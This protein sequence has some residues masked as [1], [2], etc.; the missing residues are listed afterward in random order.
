MITASG[1]G[2]GLDVNSLVRQLVQSERASFDQAINRQRSRVEP[3]LSAL[4]EFKAAASRV[5]EAANPLR[6]AANYDRKQAV[7][8]NT[9]ALRATASSVAVPATYQVQV[10]NIATTQ[11]IASTS[12]SSVD[13]VV[14]KGNLV[15]RFGTTDYSGGSYNGFTVNPDRNPFTITIDDDN[16]SLI[17]VMQA[18]NESNQGVNASIVNDGAGFRLLITTQQ[19]GASNSIEIS[20]TG[21]TDGNNND[22]N[23]LSR[24]AFNATASNMQQTQAANDLSFT[25]N[26]LTIQNQNNT[27]ATAI[28]GVTLNF[29]E[30][31]SSPFTL[32]VRRDTD[33]ILNAA[34]NFV[35]AYNDFRA[36]VTEISGYDQ[37]TKTAGPLIS[38]FT[39]RSVVRDIEGIL[40]GNLSNLPA[41][42][43]NLAE[44]GFTTNKGGILELNEERF[45]DI[46]V[47]RPQLMKRL[48]DTTLSAS[49]PQVTLLSTSPLTEPG[50]Y[51]VEIFSLATAGSYTGD[52]VLPNFAGGATFDINGSNNVIQLRV[53]GVTT[54]NITLTN[55]LYTSGES[56]ASMLQ[57][58]IN[59]NT[60]LT[61]ANLQVAVTY[62]A[63]GNNLFFQVVDA[64]GSNSRIDVLGGQPQI[65]QLGLIPRNGDAGSDISGSINGVT[66]Q[67]NGNT[68]TA[69]SGNP[70][71]GIVI[72]VEGDTIGSRGNVSF[73][74]GIWPT[75][76]RYLGLV[77]GDEGSVTQRITGLERQRTSINQRAERLDERFKQVEILY[78]TQFN[79]LDRL[80]SQL[81]STSSFL[82]S[83]LASIN[84]IRT[85]SN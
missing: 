37:A 80:I 62:N 29:L 14:G 6:I 64:V 50:V 19:T 42:F 67:G 77:L 4:G 81:R 36:K 82:E 61:N 85:N 52:G 32:T 69:A 79:N 1:L 84:S 48:Y 2:S 51:P 9:T 58:R 23:G 16:N 18:I 55:G 34:R 60:A 28:P 83:Q 56:L 3:N 49:D 7:S 47:N 26:G 25:L 38:D 73:T 22:N 39:T 65:S 5:Q 78:R 68:L 30:A 8:S 10:N 45:T 17:G 63:S 31:T 27:V 57:S 75:L 54:G 20:V 41:D 21:D 74:Q 12:F 53:N 11:T 46:L 44:F 15:F 76:N 24:L 72:R 35:Q 71:Q 59:S 70:A 40:R 66:A 43:R 33:I 13:D